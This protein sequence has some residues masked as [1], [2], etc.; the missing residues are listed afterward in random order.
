M[1]NKIKLSDADKQWE[2]EDAVRTL[3]RAETIRNN[4]DLMGGVKKNIDTMHKMMYGGSTFK[5]GPSSTVL[6]K[7]KCGGGMK[8]KAKKK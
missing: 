7:K 3:Q 2:I 1:A 6:D 5:K 8:P 4:K